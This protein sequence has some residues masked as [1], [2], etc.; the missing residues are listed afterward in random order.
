MQRFPFNIFCNTLFTACLDSFP[1]IGYKGSTLGALRGKWD[2]AARG[3]SPEHPTRERSV[4]MPYF[5]FQGK[6]IEIDEDGFITDPTVWDDEM[7]KALAKT[8]GVEEMTE[9]HWKVARYLRNY[10]LQFGIAPMIRKLCKETGF[11]LKEIYE[12]YPSGPA[13]GGCKVA[14]LPKPT[15]CV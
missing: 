14:G 11:S 12:L 8:E 7:A 15:G 9:S 3:G 10:Y 13:K 2:E 5:E 6:Q 1:S 4:F